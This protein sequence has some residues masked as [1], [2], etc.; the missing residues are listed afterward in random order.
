MLTDVRVALLKR[1]PQRIELVGGPFC[2]VVLYTR[3][4]LLSDVLFEM[5]HREGRSGSAQNP[6]IKEWWPVGGS[7]IAL[8][9][10]ATAIRPAEVFEYQ[11]MKGDLFLFSASKTQSS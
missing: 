6:G 7:A 8:V 1:L 4:N 10:H 3:S 9:R 5:L 2:G 11:Q